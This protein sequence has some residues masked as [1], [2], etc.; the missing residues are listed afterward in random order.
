M[1]AAHFDFIINYI[2]NR[3]F[4]QYLIL[5]KTDVFSFFVNVYDFPPAF[6]HN[7]QNCT[8]GRRAAA[9][10]TAECPMFACAV[11]RVKGYSSKATCGRSAAA[12]NTAICAMFACAV[13]RVKGCSSKATC[14]RSTSAGNT[15]ECPV[16]V[17]AVT[18]ARCVRKAL[19]SLCPPSPPNRALSAVTFAHA[20]ALPKRKPT[21]HAV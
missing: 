20:P 6:P 10:D 11:T 18:R 16:S 19:F 12:G 4:F 7:P 1:K 3:L 13:T 14:G 17:C 9:G 15:A 5:T 8:S 2:T 21:P